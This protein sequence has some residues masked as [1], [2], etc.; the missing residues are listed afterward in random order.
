MHN[1]HAWP[2]AASIRA[3]DHG[4]DGTLGCRELNTLHGYSFNYRP[5]ALRAT[6]EPRATGTKPQPSMPTMW[7]LSTHSSFI[8][9]SLCASSEGSGQVSLPF[10]SEA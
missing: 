9:V 6:G 2:G 7:A 4:V 10:T 8:A 1:D 3:G 5:S